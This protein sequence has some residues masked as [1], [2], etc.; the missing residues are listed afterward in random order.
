[1]TTFLFLCIFAA[2]FHTQLL[3]I[4]HRNAYHG[5]IANKHDTGAEVAELVLDDCRVK[6]IVLIS[7][8]KLS[9]NSDFAGLI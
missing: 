8:A 5:R 6:E 7:F 3:K 9:L 2:P 4:I 1:M